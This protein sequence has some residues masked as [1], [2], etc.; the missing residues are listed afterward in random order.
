MQALTAVV[1][2]WSVLD[3]TRVVAVE[4]AINNLL[5]ILLSEKHPE[6]SVAL[7]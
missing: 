6:A 2:Y 3:W 4:E 1:L 7:Q 5:C